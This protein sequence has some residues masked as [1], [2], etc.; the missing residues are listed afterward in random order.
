M[1]LVAPRKPAAKPSSAAGV[2]RSE[3][4]SAASVSQVDADADDNSDYDGDDE[5]GVRSSSDSNKT[6]RNIALSSPNK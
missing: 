1:S 5:D 2:N 6:R 3:D 4:S